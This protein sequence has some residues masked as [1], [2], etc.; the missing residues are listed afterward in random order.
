MCIRTKCSE[1]TIAITY[2]RRN[3]EMKKYIPLTNGQELQVEVSYHRD[4]RVRGYYL[5]VTPVTRGEGSISYLLFSGVT[6]LVLQVARK[7]AK[8]ERE[9]I[10]L[11][12]TLEQE[13]IAT[14]L[15]KENL[16]ICE[17]K[18]CVAWK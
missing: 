7:S 8:V 9:A 10:Q 11:A 12:E 18:E 16:T 3:E 13:L 4:S 17:P 2:K 15:E 1:Y 5:S 14:V 6:K